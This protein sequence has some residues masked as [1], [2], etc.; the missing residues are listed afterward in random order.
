MSAHVFDLHASRREPF[1][2]LQIDLVPPE[3]GVYV[4]YDLAGPV[5]AGRSRRD[6]RR[7]L[8][9]HLDGS[10]NRNVALARRTGALQSLSFTYCCLPASEHADVERVLIASLGVAKYANLRREGLYEDEL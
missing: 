8:R 1:D 7:R 9:S 6:I 3:S 10:G 4:I 2:R 5:Y